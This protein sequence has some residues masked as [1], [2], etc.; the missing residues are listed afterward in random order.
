MTRVMLRFSKDMADQPVT[1]KVILQSGTP[2]NILSANIDQQGGA[3][4]AEIPA[5]E[6]DRMITAFR[7][8]G[9]IVD[10]RELIERDEDRCT[11]CGACLSLC[12]VAAYTFTQGFLVEL[13]EEKCIGSTCGQCVNAC[14]TRAISL[15][16]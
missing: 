7:A 13:D 3:M 15:I 14:P 5:T 8:R 16:G 1:S 12:P 6:A 11:D 4:L 9:V 10:I 2:V